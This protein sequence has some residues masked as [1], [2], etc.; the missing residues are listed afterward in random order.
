MVATYETIQRLTKQARPP[1]PLCVPGIMSAPFRFNPADCKSAFG[2]WLAEHISTTRRDDD[3][4]R[5]SLT[6]RHTE[7]DL[8]VQEL[9]KKM[10]AHSIRSEADFNSMLSMLEKWSHEQ[11]A[12]LHAYESHFFQHRVIEFDWPV[13]GSKAAEGIEDPAAFFDLCGAKIRRLSP[14]GVKIW[15]GDSPPA[16]LRVTAP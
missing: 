7:I 10:T 15:N 1:H 12:M 14:I 8:K 11:R 13:L 5:I 2:R 6:L 3:L 9:T 4:S 16:T